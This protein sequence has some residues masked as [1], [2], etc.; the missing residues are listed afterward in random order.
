MKIQELVE[1][2]QY[3]NKY[4][5]P[6]IKIQT[7]IICPTCKTNP[8]QITLLTAHTTILNKIT[9]KN[10]EKTTTNRTP[11]KPEKNGIQ[12]RREWI[13]NY[14]KKYAF[15]NPTDIE[16]IVKILEKNLTVK[17]EW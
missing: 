12:Q 16:T 1:L 3:K 10:C 5:L 15:I 17:R 6:I 13:I 2:T 7:T 4:Y 14:L 9:C 8:A 11:F